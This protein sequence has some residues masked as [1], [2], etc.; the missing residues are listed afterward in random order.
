[1]EKLSGINKGGLSNTIKLITHPLQWQVAKDLPGITNGW[2]LPDLDTK[3]WIK[4]MLDTTS[5]IPRKGNNIQPN[6]TP[7]ALV[8]WYRVEFTLPDSADQS[9]WLARINASGNGYM[10]LNGKNIGRYWEAGPQRE[11]YLP[12]CWLKFGKQEKNV[13]VFGLRQT[14]SG[15]LVKALEIAACPNLDR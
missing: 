5:V 8:T 3:N 11:F 1:M 14:N 4:V 9:T 13:L 7:T 12:E 10:W 2:T 15:A 6:E